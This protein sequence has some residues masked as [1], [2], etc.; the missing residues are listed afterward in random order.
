M[1][2]KQNRI[3]AYELLFRSGDMLSAQV[4]DS[5]RATASV[6]ANALNNV[7]IKQLIGDPGCPS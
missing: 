2:D 4:T 7:G 6:I 1:L 5:A 3:V